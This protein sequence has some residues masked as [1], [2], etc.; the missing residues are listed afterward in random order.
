LPDGRYKIQF[1]YGDAMSAD[2]RGFREP[3]AREFPAIETLVTRQT[4]TEIQ[5]QVL[6]F[7]LYTVAGGNVRP[8]GINAADFNS[9]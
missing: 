2:C 7:T 3:P 5:T 8:Y 6:S 9:D 1:A 4:A